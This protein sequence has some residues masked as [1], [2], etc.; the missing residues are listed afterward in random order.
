MTIENRTLDGAT[1][2][3]SFGRTFTWS[4]RYIEAVSLGNF[5]ST[6]PDTL[7]LTMSGAAWR[8]RRLGLDSESQAAPLDVTIT[9]TNDGIERRID[10][11]QLGDFADTT[12]TLHTSR[13]RFIDGGLG[14]NFTL[15]LG[16]GSLNYAGLWDT[17]SNTITWGSGSADALYLG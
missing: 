16:A 10:W 9:D 7:N 17:D 8:I 12:V 3:T 5:G 13:I 6:T 4:N 11:L 15:T 14:G 2:F 1:T